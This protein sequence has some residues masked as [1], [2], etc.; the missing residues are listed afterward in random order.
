MIESIARVW[1]KSSYSGADNACV[2]V[3]TP[4]PRWSGLHSRF[5]GP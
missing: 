3:L 4:P 5:E 1:R 2:E